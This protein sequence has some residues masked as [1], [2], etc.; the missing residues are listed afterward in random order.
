MNL[1]LRIIGIVYGVFGVLALLF[2]FLAL[3]VTGKEVPAKF[4]LA[5]LA[6]VALDISAGVLGLLI[7][8]SFWTLKWW[9]RP[10]AL[11]FNVVSLMILMINLFIAFNPDL[12]VAPLPIPVLLLGIAFFGS[13]TAI[14][15]SRRVRELMPNRGRRQARENGRG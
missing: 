14:L 5:Y 4:F 3:P 10:L 9:G 11:L 12:G 15:L 13:I 6:M 2:L 1:T 7:M 8:Y